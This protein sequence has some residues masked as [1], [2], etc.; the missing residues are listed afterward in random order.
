LLQKGLFPSYISY[1][2]KYPKT[3]INKKEPP[4]L[5]LYLILL[6]YLKSFTMKLTSGSKNI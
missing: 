2:G 4:R 3:L 1:S 6:Q 5:F